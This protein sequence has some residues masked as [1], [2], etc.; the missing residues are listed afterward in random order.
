MRSGGAR[1]RRRSRAGPRRTK[2]P[3]TATA[4][5]I[6]TARH[7]PGSSRR[8]TSPT[9][10]RRPTRRRR[11]DR[12]LSHQV[13]GTLGQAQQAWADRLVVGR[14]VGLVD[15][16]PPDEQP[17]DDR[18]GHHGGQ[19][20]GERRP[21]RVRGPVG[22]EP[23]G[24]RPQDCPAIARDVTDTLA[25][26]ST[27]VRSCDRTPRLRQTA[28]ARAA[29]QIPATTA[30]WNAST[31]EKNATCTSTMAP[32]GGVV[33]GCVVAASRKPAMA[34]TPAPNARAGARRI[35]RVPASTLSCVA[36]A[37][38]GPNAATASSAAWS[39]AEPSWARRSVA[40]SRW[41]RTSAVIRSS[42]RRPTC[43]RAVRS[44]R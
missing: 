13:D 30:T 10:P 42:A 21:V 3:T 25:P 29:A 36:R 11:L 28:A 6:P 26:R 39:G 33:V 12:V 15:P 35:A 27:S 19:A 16:Q 14:V 18:G 22:R 4:S 41:S 24:R 9:P 20:D 38:A 44:P 1:V 5:A 43:R 40:S 23:H 7:R 2:P 17:A 34:A 8:G 31:A 32:V 37:R